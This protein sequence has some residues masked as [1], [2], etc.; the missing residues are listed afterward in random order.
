MRDGVRFCAVR[1]VAVREREEGETRVALTPD[2]VATLRRAG[3]TVVLQVGAGAAAGFPDES[4]AEQ[5]AP[6]A[7]GTPELL[8][9]ADLLVKIH[10]PVIEEV[11]ALPEGAASVSL[12]YPGERLHVVHRLVERKVTAF[13]L[14]LLPRT[15]RAQ[16]MDV[17]SSMSTLAGY[18]AALLGAH[19]SGALFPLLM[20]AAGTVAPATVL[21]IGAG[22]AGLQAIATAKRLGARVEAYDVRLAVQEEVESLGARF[23]QVPGMESAGGRGGYA[24][25]LT[26]EERARLQEALRARVAASDVVVTT[27]L[28]P[29]RPAPRIITTD[30][31]KEMKEGAV[32]VDM[33]APTGGNCEL[34]RAGETVTE[35]GVTIVGPRNLPATMPRPASRMFAR[36]LAAFVQHLAPG[37]ELRLDLEDDILDAC[38][39]THAGEVR[40]EETRKAMEEERA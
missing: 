19:H 11:S 1:I 2:V 8:G 5:D 35:H 34:T 17:L 18:R 3:H 22:V 6:T 12:L 16:S 24:R 28:I 39:V 26:A 37:G 30:M 31:V 15:T 32:I 10:P 9:S 23:V 25:E 38:S 36:N 20:T 4:Y 7:E 40:H 29:G 14:E 27:A 33:A 13:A 21:V